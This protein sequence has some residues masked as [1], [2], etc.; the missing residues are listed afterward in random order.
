MTLGIRCSSE[1]GRRVRVE[2]FESHNGERCDCIKGP[3]VMELFEGDTVELS[4][5]V[6]CPNCDGMKRTFALNVKILEVVDE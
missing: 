3:S 2:L 6:T 4:E 5:V 1:P